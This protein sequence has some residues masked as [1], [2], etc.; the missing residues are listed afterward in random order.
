[1][2]RRTSGDI[3]RDLSRL[4]SFFRSQGLKTAIQSIFRLGRDSSSSGSSVTLPLPR[5]GTVRDLHEPS[6]V[7]EFDIGALRRVRKQTE[8]NAMKNGT[9][10]GGFEDVEADAEDH[11]HHGELFLSFHGDSEG[12][13]SNFSVYSCASEGS[14]VQ[15]NGGLAL[16]EETV[17]M[18]TTDL[19]IVDAPQTKGA[20]ASR[21]VEINGEHG[22]KGDIG[23]QSIISHQM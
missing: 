4:P 3:A 13:E 8:K 20:T 1:M 2:G 14:E 5:T 6:S 17:Q 7:G 12:S 21:V 16:R 23:L 19:H 9:Y 15:V 22:T 10:T 18:H 11:S